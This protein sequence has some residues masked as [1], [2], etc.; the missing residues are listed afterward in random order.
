MDG[1]FARSEP[2]VRA[3]FDRLVGVAA[4]CGAVQVSALKT[5]IAINAPKLMGG[6][7]A[8][9]GAL[10]VSLVLPGARSHR[11][12]VGRQ[13]MSEIRISHRFTLR[14]EGDFDGAFE[15]LVREAWELAAE[16]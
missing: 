9:R 15:D 13:A 14:E 10:R 11:T 3:I 16:G 6:A 1:H 4:S 2:H 5:M 8:Q 7:G 12:L